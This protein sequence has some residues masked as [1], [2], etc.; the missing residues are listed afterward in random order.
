MSRAVFVWEA[1]QLSGGAEEVG[2]LRSAGEQEGER[3][4]RRGECVTVV[5]TMG[6]ERSGPYVCLFFRRSVRN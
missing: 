1:S 3:G 5:L 4:E 2:S 6:R